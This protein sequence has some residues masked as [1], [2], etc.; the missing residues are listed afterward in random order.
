MEVT[1]RFTTKHEAMVALK[2]EDYLDCLRDFQEW[3]GSASGL[4]ATSQGVLDKFHEFIA[5]YNFE[6]N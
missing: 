1:L 2:A 6:L 3:L 5:L 4:T